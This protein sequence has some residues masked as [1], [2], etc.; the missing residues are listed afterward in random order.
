M[1]LERRRCGDHQSLAQ[2]WS[3]V[4]RRNGRARLAT[5]AGCPRQPEATGARRRTSNTFTWRWVTDLPASSPAAVPRPIRRQPT[6]AYGI[7]HNVYYVQS[8]PDIDSATEP[9]QWHPGHHPGPNPAVASLSPLVAGAPQGATR[10]VLA[11][12]AHT[13]SRKVQSPLVRRTSPDQ[14][15]ILR[16]PK[17]S[18]LQNSTPADPRPP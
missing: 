18:A 10:H 8:R 16:E 2:F 15:S 12:H 14:R 17:P 13:S 5:R 4:P 11:A 7:S 9:G 6:G 1:E 3:E